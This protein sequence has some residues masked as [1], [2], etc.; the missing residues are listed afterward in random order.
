MKK[1]CTIDDLNSLYQEA[2]SVDS[3]LLAEQRSNLLLDAGEHYSNKKS[4]YWNR[5]KDSKD[6]SGDQKLRLTKN[7]IQKIVKTYVNNIV[8]YAPSVKVLP[9]NEK[10][11]KDQKAAELNDSVWQDLRGRHKLRL[12]TID[13]AND[14][15][16]VGEVATKIFWDP[17]AGKFLG[18]EPTYETDEA[19]NLVTDSEGNPVQTGTTPKFTG[20]LVYER[21]YGFNL[22]RAP[23]CQWMGDGHPW[24]IR[25]LADIDEMKIKIGDDAEKLKYLQEAS[26]KTYDIFD[27][28]SGDYAKTKN[29]VMLREWYFPISANYPNGYF[30]IATETGILWEGELPFGIW[31]IAFDGFDEIT[32]SPRKRSIIKQ[33]RP[34]QIEINRAAS[35]MAEHQI[36][37]GDDK[38]LIQSGST[39]KNGGQLPGV[40]QWT[41]TGAKPDVLAGRPGNQYVD[42]MKLNIQEMYEIAN[43]VEDS[44]EKQS[45]NVQDPFAML[46]SSLRNRKKFSIY[47]EKF[48]SFLT[49]VCLIS[50][51]LSKH[52]YTDDFIIPAIGR[53]EIVNIEEFK[54]TEELQYQVKLEP[55]SDDIETQMGKQMMVNHL[56]QYVGPQMDKESIGKVMRHAQFGNWRE[57][58]KDFTMKTDRA[59]N[60]IL[61]LDRGQPMAPNKYDDAKYMVQ[62]LVD[63]VSQSDFDYL[64][65]QVRADYEAMIVHYENESNRQLQEIAAA[66]KGFIPSGGPRVKADM[67]VNSPNN[68]NR[69]EKATIPTESLVWLIEQLGKQGSTQEILQ[70]MNQGAVA[71]MATRLNQQLS[72]QPGP[73]SPTDGPQSGQPYPQGVMQ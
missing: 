43:V 48:E 50:L 37:L 59:D 69:V 9:H 60:M 72:N 47:S 21:V 19:G 56:L 20:D 58:F 73:T 14:F 44:A 6:I 16:K 29:Q 65:E 1:K 38:M 33:L 30:Y 26:K 23:P 18:E 17:T 55:M 62:R 25:K 31:P 12:K 4:K 54:N 22:L 34:Y 2:E 15:I 28:S 67:Y 53:G 11:Q 63:R 40:R 36:T 70:Q 35:K 49:Q 71:D 66:Q 27:S 41:Y 13:W 32:T 45:A 10:E 61:A 24:C 57:A 7:H 39:V 64:P 51:R 8:T 52:Y 5:I 3:S 42:Y 68:P 46:F